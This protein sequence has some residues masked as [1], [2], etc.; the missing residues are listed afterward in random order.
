MSFQRIQMCLGMLLLFAAVMVS[1]A[2]AQSVSATTKKPDGWFDGFHRFIAQVKKSSWEL[3]HSLSET[4]RPDWNHH[5]DEDPEFVKA[6]PK[7]AASIRER[8]HPSTLPWTDETTTEPAVTTPAEEEATTVQDTPLTDAEGNA[9]DPHETNT[10]AQEPDMTDRESVTTLPNTTSTNEMATLAQETTIPTDQ[11][12]AGGIGG[13]QKLNGTEEDVRDQDNA[14]NYDEGPDH[15]KSLAGQG[16][17]E[18]HEEGTP[19]NEIP[20]EQYEDEHEKKQESTDKLKSK[21]KDIHKASRKQ[22]KG[23]PSN[24]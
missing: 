5:L 13:A 10:T 4:P 12:E 16:D 2:P 23:M 19:N 6:H 15:E 8:Y 3:I 20:N 11:L 9:M 14:P 22:H 17:G 18:A 7:E 21:Y 1:A 24:P